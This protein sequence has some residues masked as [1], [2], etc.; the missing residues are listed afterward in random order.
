MSEEIVPTRANRRGFLLGAG[1]VG[2]A[3][4]G[5]ATAGSAL[6]STPAAPVKIDA[7]AAASAGPVFLYLKDAGRGQLAILHG[8]Q[9]TVVTDHAAVAHILSVVGR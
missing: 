7:A 6:A 5:V 3:A 8:E 2:L 9:E 1:T 4:T